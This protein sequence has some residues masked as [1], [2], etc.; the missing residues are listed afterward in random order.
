[1]T[2]IEV[3][4]LTVRRGDRALLRSVD[5]TARAGEFIGVVG[6]NGAG[7]S[8]LLRALAGLEG[9]AEGRLTLNGAPVAGLKPI[10]RARA[11]AYLPQSRDV[12]WAVTA[13]AVVSLGRFAYGAPHRL[14]PADRAAV[15]AALAATDSTSFR[16]RV[17]STRA[18]ARGG[19]AGADRRRA[20]RRTR[21]SPRAVDHRTLEGEGGRRRA[22]HRRP[23][24]SGSRA[25]VLHAADR[26]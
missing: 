14:G 17:A 8:T 13:E 7:K 11:L 12:H 25:A 3:E 24:R 26:H 1:M 5:F 20:D 23:S 6:P 22:R 4:K 19:R 21:P 10:E 9:A 16:S 18:G 2:T 15:E